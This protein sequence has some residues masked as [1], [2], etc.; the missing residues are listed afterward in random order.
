MKRVLV[1]QH[2]GCEGLGTLGQV[3]GE[4]EAHCV[5]SKPFLGDPTAGDLRGYDGL[6]VLG[7]PQSVYEEDRYP[8]LS[9]ERALIQ[10]AL[11]SGLP[12][13]GIC[14]GSQII[15]AALEAEVRPSGYKEIG[16][17][18][19]RLAPGARNDPLFE[20]FP[21]IFPAFHWHGDVYDL[22]PPAASSSSPPLGRPCKGSSSER[23][24]G[25]SSATSRSP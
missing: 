2:V 17:E 5:Y 7:G 14:L 8:Y 16:W 22:P 23:G 20:G 19:V 13:M 10:Q 6:V 12:I 4:A 9:A 1:I 18:D 15:A 24:S 11:A 3:L 25:A 21:S